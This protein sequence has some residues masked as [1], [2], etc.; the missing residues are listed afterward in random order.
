MQHRTFTFFPLLPQDVQEL[1][2][3]KLPVLD[4]FF[5][6]VSS[7]AFAG[8]SRSCI[9][10]RTGLLQIAIAQDSMPRIRYLLPPTSPKFG[11]HWITRKCVSSPAHFW[12]LLGYGFF[13]EDFYQWMATKTRVMLHLINSTK[14]TAISIANIVKFAILKLHVENYLL[15]PI[16][17]ELEDFPHRKGLSNLNLKQLVLT[18]IRSNN[19][20][21]LISLLQQYVDIPRNILNSAVQAACTIDQSQKF[22]PLLLPFFN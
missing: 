6:L 13:V 17:G 4:R 21:L 8:L 22:L 3:S 14:L 11:H 10:T 12:S 18:I 20:Y 1:I 15:I 16:V 19:E 9:S 7:K 2:V 5:F